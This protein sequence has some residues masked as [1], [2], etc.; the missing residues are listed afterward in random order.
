[1]TSET[2]V[3]DIAVAMPASVRVFEKYQID[4]C[5]NGKRPLDAACREAGLSAEALMAEIREAGRSPAGADTDWSAAPLA[6]LIGHIIERHH[7]YLKAELPQIRTRLDKVV[8]NH[9]A[10]RPWLAAV[11]STFLALQAELM[12]HLRK[13]EMVLFP[14]VEALESGSRAEACFASVAGPI[15]VMMAEHDSAGHAL[16]EM[17]RLSNGYAAPE[18]GCPGFRALMHELAALEADLHRHI[19][20]ENN[21]LFPGAIELEYS[22]RAGGR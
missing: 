6:S 2:T 5:C 4:F 20:L 11:R 7:E 13:E 8:G 21:I 17:R 14:Y 22:I 10:E 19:H 16:A 18:D 1:M 15:Q 3:R 9:I 12:D